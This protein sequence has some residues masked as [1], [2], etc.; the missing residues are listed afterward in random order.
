MR[1]KEGFVLR[2]LGDGFIIVPTGNAKLRFNGMISFNASGALIWRCLDKGLDRD[3]TATE[4]TEVY[5]ID[6]ET[7]LADIDRFYDKLREACLVEE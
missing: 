2:E 5:D 6:R 7:A 4:M 1:I 3:R